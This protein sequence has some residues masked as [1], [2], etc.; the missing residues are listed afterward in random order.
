MQILWLVA[1]IAFLILEA[2]TYQMLS[3]WFVVGSIGALIATLCGAEFWL[4]M[5]IFLVLSVILL[6]VFRPLAVKKLKPKFKTNADATVGKKVVI[7][8]EVDNVKGTGE[9]KLDGMVWTVR[10]ESDKVL[11]VGDVAEVKRIEGVKLIV[12]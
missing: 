8:Q 9:A 1:V 5:T 12:D 4:Q 7:T 6:I 2:G 11:S 3:I 10:T